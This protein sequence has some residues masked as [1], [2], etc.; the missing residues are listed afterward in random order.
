M[1]IQRQQKDQLL[2]DDDEAQAKKRQKF[3]AGG[4]DGSFS[5]IELQELLA[6]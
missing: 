2:V 1:R 5:Q 4:I 6:D 3:Q